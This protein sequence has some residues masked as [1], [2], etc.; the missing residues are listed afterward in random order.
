MT[1]Q[2]KVDAKRG[3]FMVQIPIYMNDLV[4]AM[5][6][7]RW[8]AHRRVWLAPV[9]RANAKYIK[10]NFRP[11]HLSK[12]AKDEVGK[13]AERVIR[14]YPPPDLGTMDAVQMDMEYRQMN[15]Q[16]GSWEEMLELRDIAM[17][18]RMGSGKSKQACDIA[19]YH[20]RAG[21][22]DH[23][24][25]VVLN[26][27]R[28]NWE[29]Q[30]HEHMACDYAYHQLES[31]KYKQYQSW[32]DSLK[33]EGW[34]KVLVVSIESLSQGRAIE[35]AEHF[36]MGGRT[37]MVV[38][39][40]M[41]IKN[42]KAIRTKMCHRLGALS[43][44]RIIMTGTPV[45]KGIEN[46]WSQFHFLD[47]EIIGFPD[48][49][50]FERRYVTKGGYENKQIVGYNNVSELMELLE[51]HAFNVTKEEALP[52]L[53]PKTYETRMLA[54]TKEMS[55]LY[56][57]VVN[58]KTL[59]DGSECTNTLTIALRL[60]QICGGNIAR[61]EGVHKGK[62][63]YETD[64]IPG[65]NPKLDELHDI[66]ESTDLPAIIWA[67]GMAE[68]NAIHTMIEKDFGPAAKIVGGLGTR[69][70][71]DQQELF[72]SGKVDYVVANPRAGGVGIDLYRA[73]L[74]VFYSDSFNWSERI[75]AE[76]RAHRKG[77][78]G[79]VHIVD[80]RIQGSV[81]MDIAEAHEMKMSMAEFVM[82][83]FQFKPMK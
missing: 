20:Y 82:G 65:N 3:K 58:K 76:D 31:G 2:I 39:E 46:L 6:S 66:L 21:D 78:T 83:Q 10:E 11:E 38:D 30:L 8:N 15:H 34:L 52:D 81:D 32:Y 74:E 36:V 80:L 71:W 70:V 9:C 79:Q 72:Q 12:A 50:A 18:W 35:Y 51:A 14:K 37:M 16:A 40:S 67:D 59:P 43:Q 75:Q 41:T 47:P 53:P 26:S 23:F 17:F 5:P 45:T 68:I 29:K 33:I 13:H 19:N 48:Y 7:R 73:K 63:L 44:K 42:H 22:I 61:F 77:Q 62:R 24:L 60:H 56:N 64:P 55:R 54:P 28:G 4:K 1:E 57:H 25:I 27:I 49:Y 69:G